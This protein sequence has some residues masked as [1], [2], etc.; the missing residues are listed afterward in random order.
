MIMHEEIIPM[1]NG[2]LLIVVT[3]DTG[4]VVMV[5]HTQEEYQSLMDNQL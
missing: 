2:N 4:E 5:E 1:E 3:Y